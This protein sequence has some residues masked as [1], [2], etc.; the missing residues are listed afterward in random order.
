V[1]V[2][3]IYLDMRLTAFTDYSLRVLMYLAA[4]PQERATIAEVA[5]AFGISQH[6]LVKVAHFLGQ[7][8][9][10]ANTRGRNGGLRFARPAHEINVGRLVRLTEGRDMP[11]EC[12]DPSTNTC[13]L[14]GGCRLKSLL[15]DAV[16]EFYAVLERYTVADLRAPRGLARLVRLTSINTGSA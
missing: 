2:E 13:Q 1:H 5:A 4:A 15:Q 6:H 14:A 9:I 12:F 8:G 11:A 10:L 7:H 3:Y 16:E